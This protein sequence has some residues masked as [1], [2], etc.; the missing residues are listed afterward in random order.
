MVRWIVLAALLSSGAA[1]AADNGKAPRVVQFSPRGVVK[2]VR[3]VTA[4]F[5]EPMVPLGDPRSRV[6]PFV[7]DC[8]EKGAARWVDSR[9]WAFDFDRD[10]PAGTRCTFTV[11]S[12]LRTLAKRPIGG[13]GAFAFST[14]G[15][16]IVRSTPYEDS[17]DVEE[18]Q[19]FVLVLDG[20]ATEASVLAHA[21]FTVKGLPQAVG[22]RLITGEA[23][24]QILKTFWREA[25]AGPVVVLQA[26]QRFPAG[27]AIKLIWGKE[28]A[29]KSGVNSAKD[30]VLGFTVRKAFDARFH[31]DRLHV[32]TGC[33]PVTPMSL[34]F[35]APVGWDQA[36]RIALVGP[37]GSRR[38]PDPS[39]T[40]QPFVE[41]VVFKGPFPESTTFHIE[42]PPDLRDDV[43]RTLANAAEYPLTVATG[44]FPPLAKFSSR[45]GIIES[46]ADPVLPV[47]LR[48]LEPA[49][50]ARLSRFGGAIARIP[51]EHPEQVLGWLRKVAWARR[52]VSVFADREAGDPSVQSFEVPKPNGPDAFEVVGIP[53]PAPGLYVVELASPKLGAALL[54]GQAPDVRAHGGAGHEL[55]G[56]LQMGS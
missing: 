16:S 50:Q 3:Q 47:T 26:K 54:G 19:A 15:P 18:E 7:I 42:L 34:R 8:V 39:D 28:I 23:R 44:S 10:L 32:M 36:S 31:C 53:L 14:G 6:A 21:R 33:L 46:K 25:V 43:G 27:A 29:A 17:R 35:S 11:R 52:S 41:S 9:T 55:V 45:F 20:E 4:R 30:Q 12:D 2:N 49:V 37:D 22:V 51:P 5:S 48:N 24:E 40:P 13:E 1:G 38:T 56:A